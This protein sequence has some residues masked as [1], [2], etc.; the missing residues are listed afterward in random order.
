MYLEMEIWSLVTS[1]DLVKAEGRKL[2][3]YPFV[4]GYHWTGSL[5]E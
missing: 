1:T 3:T 5:G 4:T 2:I